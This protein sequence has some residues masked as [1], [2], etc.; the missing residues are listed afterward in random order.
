MKKK[1]FNFVESKDSEFEGTSSYFVHT[2]TISTVMDLH[3]AAY[4]SAQLYQGTNGSLVFTHYLIPASL[5]H[6]DHS[7]RW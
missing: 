4:Q 6:Q 2:T 5:S 1:H 7:R 3:V